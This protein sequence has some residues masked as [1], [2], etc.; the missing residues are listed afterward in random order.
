MTTGL[1][2]VTEKPAN[3]EHKTTNR[4][5]SCTVKAG[6]RKMSAEGGEQWRGEKEKSTIATETFLH[7]LACLDHTPPKQK[8]L[9]THLIQSLLLSL[10]L[11]HPHPL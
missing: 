7:P 3:L 4:R 8:G 2:K 10:P 9:L 1:A 11:L 6:Q 5:L